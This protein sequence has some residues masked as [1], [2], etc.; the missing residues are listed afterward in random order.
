MNGRKQQ[1][2]RWGLLLFPAHIPSAIGMMR[3]GHLC[4][5]RSF[6]CNTSPHDSLYLCNEKIKT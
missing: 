1:K 4:K 2:R 6:T 5:F 3:F